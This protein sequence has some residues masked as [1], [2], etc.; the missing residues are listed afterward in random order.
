[1]PD[2]VSSAGA[3]HTPPSTTVDR[4]DQMGKDTF[5]KL[6]VAQLRYQDPSNPADSSQMMSQTA[7]FSQVE[8]LEQM[9]EQNASLLA[10]QRSSSAGALVGRTITYTDTT[11]ASASGVVTSV[12]L[13]T[14]SADAVA[15]IGSTPVEMG[16]ITEIAQTT[17][18]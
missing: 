1:M 10:L 14:D 17:T 4:P 8:K 12:R 2:A 11:G 9:V 15:M 3:A 18:S 6:L 7:T 5:L 13:G 16:R